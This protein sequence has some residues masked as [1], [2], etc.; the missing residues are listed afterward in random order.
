MPE[1]DGA[2]ATAKIRELE[3][4]TP[5]DTHPVFVCA[6]TANIF[7]AD[8]RRCFDSGMNEYLNKPIKLASVA[9]ILA[10]AATSM[11]S[12]VELQPNGR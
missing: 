7:P 5:P 8:R 2:E 9:K 10:D 12:H 3:Q 6:V 4:S 1:M 11:N